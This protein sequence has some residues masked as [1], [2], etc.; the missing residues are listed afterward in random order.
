MVVMNV[1]FNKADDW[2]FKN[3]QWDPRGRSPRAFFYHG[4]QTIK[5]ACSSTPV[6]IAVSNL[7][8][9]HYHGVVVVNGGAAKIAPAIKVQ[10][11]RLFTQV[12]A[13][14]AQQHQ[15]L[16]VDGGTKD[17]IMEANGLACKEFDWQYQLLGISPGGV[18]EL[19]D[20]HP[21]DP[22]RFPCPTEY[23]HH[24]VILFGEG[25]WGSETNY[26]FEV[27]KE[28]AKDLPSV[29]IICNGGGITAREVLANVMQN[30]H[31]IAVKGSGRFADHL[32]EA[33]E[34]NHIRPDM[35]G[36]EILPQI[37]LG[38]ALIHIVPLDNPI[39]FRSKI[40]ELLGISN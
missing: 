21:I 15:L 34:T 22:A 4:V 19:E 2:H 3:P 6:A 33:I 12:L 29:A 28:V 31:I 27:V 8:L 20:C 35:I 17:G 32:V 16:L 13:P 39:G 37:L 18:T 14:I 23:N 24:Q 30:R 38:K 1:A 5:W 40:E 10:L 26:L 9:R 36:A 25:D 7:S 11:I